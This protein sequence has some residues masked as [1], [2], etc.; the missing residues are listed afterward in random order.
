MNLTELL[1]LDRPLVCLDLES[2]GVDPRTDR[3][4]QVG[5]VKAYPDG[6]VTEWETLVDPG[7]VSIP[8]AASDV[9]GITNE[10]VAGCTHCADPVELHSGTSGHEF[11]PVPMFRQLAPTLAKGLE[12]CDVAGYNLGS[13]DVKL[14]AAEFERAGTRWAPGRIVDGFKMAQRANPRNLTWFVEEYVLKDQEGRP[15]GEQIDFKAHDALHD[16]RQTLRGI[17]AFLRR[18]PD[19]PRDVQKLHDMF[20]VAPRDANSLDPDGKIIWKG[21][22]ACVGFGA[23]HNGKSLREVKALDPGYLHW[24]LRGEFGETVKKICADALEGRFPSRTKP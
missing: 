21:A 19:F 24:I 16:A 18:H 2:T 5:L 7:G 6:R 11:K 23:K 17:A 9:H 12:G 20:F 4:V 14:L 10:R 15:T 22:E 13:F 8:K 1:P 3:I